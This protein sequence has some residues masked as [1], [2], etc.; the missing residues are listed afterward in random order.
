MLIFIHHFT[1]HRGK[2]IP[3][4]ARRD[5]FIFAMSHEVITVPKSGETSIDC[6]SPMLLKGCA[7][8][9]RSMCSRYGCFRTLTY[10][11]SS[12]AGG[13]RVANPDV[14]H[15][16]L[17]SERMKVSGEPGSAVLRGFIA[18]SSNV[19]MVACCSA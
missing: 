6:L 9:G 12:S 14:L 11:N 1:N 8:L 4:F 16:F 19:W 13:V 7:V 17:R 10:S 18:P 15:Y 5:A 2:N 3:P